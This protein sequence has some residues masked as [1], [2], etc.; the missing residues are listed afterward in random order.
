MGQEETDLEAVTHCILWGSLLGGPVGEV[1]PRIQFFP[2][3]LFLSNEEWKSY[4]ML[5]SWFP[6][7]V[8]QERYLSSQGLCP[9]TIQLECLRWDPGH[10]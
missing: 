3:Y 10:L 4:S 7:F 6:D 8:P 5:F 9:T 2:G 1:L